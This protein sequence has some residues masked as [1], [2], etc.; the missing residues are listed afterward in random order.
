MG[1]PIDTLIKDIIDK[2]GVVIARHDPILISQTIHAELMADNAKMQQAL[3]QQHKED[4]EGVLLRF[5]DDT[6]EKSERI[7]NAA[8]TTSKEAMTDILHNAAT[9]TAMTIKKE[10]DDVLAHSNTMSHRAETA[11]RINLCASVIT[12]LSVLSAVI[13]MVFH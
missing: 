7:L 4:L 6:K 8:L 2:H 9:I 5:G 1:T 13:W 11:A 10:V 3:L 12:F